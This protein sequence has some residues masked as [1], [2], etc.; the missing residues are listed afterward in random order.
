MVVAFILFG[1][2][3]FAESGNSQARKVLIF[4]AVNA[5]ALIQTYFV[6]YVLMH[7]IFP[8]AT[9]VYYA[10]L[11]ARAAAIVTPIFTSFLGHKYFTF[12]Q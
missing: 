6:Y 11:I 1:R 7:V 9:F 8:Y 3:V 5:A 12:R 10:D 4:I 2:D